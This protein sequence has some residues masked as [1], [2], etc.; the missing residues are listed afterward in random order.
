ML[1][2][3]SITT[4]T[5]TCSFLLHIFVFSSPIS[6]S[7]SPH[8]LSLSGCFA[9]KF[10]NFRKY[11]GSYLKNLRTYY[12][13]HSVMNYGNKAFSV[14]DEPT[15]MPKNNADMADVMGNREGLSATDTM[16]LNRYYNC[17]KLA[18]LSSRGGTALIQAPLKHF[19]KSCKVR[20]PVTGNRSPGDL[21]K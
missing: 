3:K 2:V 1:I 13:F 14:N 16:E 12:D 4:V 19:S 18:A 15:I 5:I 21:S 8:H 9:D 10:I 7:S 17:C 20:R 11:N 6:L